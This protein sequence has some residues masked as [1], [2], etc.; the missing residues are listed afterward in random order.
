MDKYDTR[1]QKLD[2]HLE[3]HPSDY[4]SAIQRK[5]LFGESVM[6]KRKKNKDKERA[7][8]AQYRKDL[9]NGKY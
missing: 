9:Q 1:I 5:I 2:V 4:Q 8:I 7:K 6:Y 3:K